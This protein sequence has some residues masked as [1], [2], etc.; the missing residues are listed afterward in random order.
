MAKKNPKKSS[1]TVSW[2]VARRVI[3]GIIGLMAVWAAYQLTRYFLYESAFF[4]V[5]KIV[6][7]PTLSVID[8][9]D[10]LKLQGRSLFVID[11]GD[12]HEKLAQKY[13]QISD[14][15]ITKKF[16][17]QIR[18][19]GVARR[20]FAQ[21]EYKNKFFTVDPNG[22]VL[23]RPGARQPDFYVIKGLPD[24]PKDIQPGARLEHNSLSSALEV[25]QIFSRN[26]SIESQQIISVDAGNLSKIILKFDKGPDVII[27]WTE[28]EQ[29]SRMLGV[30]LSQMQTDMNKVRYIDLRFKE[31]VIGRD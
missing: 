8:R 9:K 16:P 24:L 13:P 11:A 19:A 21:V 20:P 10:L 2:P 7:S 18:V 30:V 3:I 15:R 5:R 23:N 6:L 31:P 25:L 22:V 12:F 29:K 4:K 28:V 17:D 14:L 26:P 27:D 1:S